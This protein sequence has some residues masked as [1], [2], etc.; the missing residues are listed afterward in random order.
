MGAA[1][2]LLYSLAFGAVVNFVQTA[3]K[4]D[5]AAHLGGLLGGV[6]SGYLLARPFEPEA[7]KVQRPW[8]V[9]A[10]S[11]GVCAALAVLAA[12]LI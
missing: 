10:V 3:P 8:Y 9:A 4:V 2:L 7:R 5:N 1:A 6:V 11:V 12:P